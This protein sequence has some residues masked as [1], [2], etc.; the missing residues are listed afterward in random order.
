MKQKILLAMILAF[1]C[2]GHVGAK[3]TH[4]GIGLFMAYAKENAVYENNYVKVFFKD[5]W[6]QIHNKSNENLYLDKESSF[7]FMNELQNCLYTGATTKHGKKDVVEKKVEA[8]GPKGYICFNVSA[9]FFGEYSALDN[10]RRGNQELAD[11]QIDLM[12]QVDALRI[13]REKNNMTGACQYFTEKESFFRLKFSF[14]ISKSKDLKDP[15]MCI[16][17]SWVSELILADYQLDDADKLKK[18]DSF[19]VNKEAN[20][21]VLH[22]W[23]DDPFAENPEEKGNYTGYDIEMEKAKFTLTDINT[24]F[25]STKFWKVLGLVAAGLT[26]DQKSIA[27]FAQSMT[28]DVSKASNIVIDWRNFMTEDEKEED[29]K[30]LEDLEDAKKQSGEKKGVLKIFKKKK[31]D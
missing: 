10:R 30:V 4:E 17:S 28:T 6:V 20:K 29:I 16:I 27:A 24:L 22:I 19:A 9:F 1:V 18:T 12:N 23:S 11:W 26:N 7:V 5:G 15:I 25:E 3:K 14:S 31:K 8:I 13:A 2:M 21:N